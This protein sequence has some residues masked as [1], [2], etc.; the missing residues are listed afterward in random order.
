M[1]KCADLCLVTPKEQQ[2]IRAII[3]EFI[4]DLVSSQN[5]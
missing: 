1:E 5:D 3:D 4:A 2:E